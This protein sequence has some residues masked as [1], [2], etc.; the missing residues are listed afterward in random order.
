[1]ARSGF[2][3]WRLD[4]GGLVEHPVSLTLADLHSLG[5]QQQITK[6]NCIQGWTGIAEWG[7]VPMTR[8]IELVKPLPQARYV[9]F[10]AMDDK[11]LTEGEGRYGFFYETAP[12]WLASK[13]QTLLATDMNGAPLPV[14]HGAPLRLRLETQLGFKM[15]KWIAAIEFTDDIASIGMGQGGWREDQQ[16][17][18]SAAGI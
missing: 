14:E 10:Y 4:V 6:H 18:A 12:V 5:Y 15:V 17:Y 3:R 7:G 13:P 11:G 8:L 2:D 16:Y 9:V 1:M